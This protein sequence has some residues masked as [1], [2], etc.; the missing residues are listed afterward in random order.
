MPRRTR[1]PAPAALSRERIVAA[2]LALVAREGLEAFSMRKVGAELGREAMSLYHFFP[3]KQHLV[4]ALVD[5]A[6]ESIEFPPGRLAPMER[7]RRLMR[8]Y[9]AMAH[10]YARLYPVIAVHRLNTPT[11]VR[12]IERLLVLA[13]EI[14]GDDE[15]AARGFRWLGYYLM[16]AAL[17]ETLGY[18]KGPSAAEPVD[19]AFIGRECPQLARSAR[20][21]QRA[22]WDATFEKGMEG[23]L[24]ALAKKRQP[25]RN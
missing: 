9:R 20:F 6:I 21:F 2:A 11:G 12:F 1:S 15:S 19:G 23:V 25:S 17:D 22:E 13:R 14:T 5:H 3:S 18:A 24:A 10:R 16:G 8:A 4:D 7:M